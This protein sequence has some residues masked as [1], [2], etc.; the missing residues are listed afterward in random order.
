[1]DI[2]IRI[3]GEQFA[4]QVISWYDKVVFTQILKSFF[5]FW[6]EQ[7]SQC[8]GASVQKRLPGPRHKELLWASCHTP[9]IFRQSSIHNDVIT[10]MDFE[11]FLSCNHNLTSYW[12]MLLSLAAS[13]YGKQKSVWALNGLFIFRDTTPVLCNSCV[14]NCMSKGLHFKISAIQELSPVLEIFPQN[15]YFHTHISN[16]LEICRSVQFHSTFSFVGLEVFFVFWYFLSPKMCFPVQDSG[17][18]FTPNG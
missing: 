7:P 4:E 14:N 6:T 9:V 12:H 16:S 10:V 1:M 5:I 17:A 3:S 2:L 13:L 11:D 15:D 8:L 18:C